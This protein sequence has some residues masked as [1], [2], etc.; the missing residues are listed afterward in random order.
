MLVIQI[1]SVSGAL[2][3]IFDKLMISCDGFGLFGWFRWYCSRSSGALSMFDNG[4]SVF[5]ESRYPFHLT[6]YQSCSSSFLYRRSLLTLIIASTSCSGQSLIM[7]G[8]G[9]V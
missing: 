9:Q 1:I 8:G 4:S 3:N 7:S 6:V 5:S 2:I